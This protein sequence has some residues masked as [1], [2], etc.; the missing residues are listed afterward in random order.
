MNNQK[1]AII[2][3][4]ALLPTTGHADIIEFSKNIPNTTTHILINGRTFEPLSGELRKLAILEFFNNEIDVRL[5]MKDNAPQNPDEMKVGFWEWWKEEINENFPEV[6]RWDYVVASETYGEKVAECL[7]AQFLPYD[8]ERTNNTVKSTDVRNDLWNQWD[9]ILPVVRENL[10]LKTVMFGQESVG[11]TT[12]SKAVAE[13]LNSRWLVEWARP[14]LETMGEELSLQKMSNIH[15]GQ[16]ALQKTFFKKASSPILILD[17]DLFSTIGYYRIMGEEVP[18][19]LIE[20]AN[21]LSS[22]FYYILPDDIP[23]IKDPLRYGGDKRESNKNF[24]INIL[25][26]FNQEYVIVPSCSVQQK[27]EWISDHIKQRF[28]DRIKNIVDFQR[29]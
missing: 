12:L 13:D 29:T 9:N 25:E 28:S 22:D 27:E 10:M 6:E 11:K 20:D 14:Y 21:R 17:T 15:Q 19:S 7:N 16:A 18:S 24:W 23:L 2:L 26:E 8:I 3:M 5:S 4:T 1:H